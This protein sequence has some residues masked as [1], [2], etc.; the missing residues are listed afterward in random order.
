MVNTKSYK[1]KY[2]SIQLNVSREKYAFLLE[3]LDER[4]EKEE[5]S[6]NFLIIKALLKEYN[7]DGEKE[8]NR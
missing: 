4:A 1:E 8:N 7:K 3:W 5:R 2:R 6:L